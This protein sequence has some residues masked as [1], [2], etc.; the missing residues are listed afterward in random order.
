MEDSSRNNIAQ[1]SLAGLLL[2]TL[3]AAVV[4]LIREPRA[5]GLAITTLQ[6]AGGTVAIALPLGTLMAAIVTRTNLP[7]RRL[8][9]AAWC[10]LLFLPLYLQASAWDS[11]FGLQGWFTQWR[12]VPSARPEVWL[13]G[14]SAAIWLHALAAIPW[15]MLIVGQGL[16]QAEA[17]LEE[18]ALLDT[19]PAGVFWNVT[20][21]RALPNILAAGLL[22]GVVTAGE[23]TIT[24]IYRVRTY[25]EELY[26]NAALTADAVE[27]GLSI[28]PHIAIVAVLA[29]LAA[30]AALWL[31]PIGDRTAPRRL[32]V[33]ELGALRLPAFGLMLGLTILALGVPVGNLIYKAGLYID[34]SSGHA[35]QAWSA[36]RF[37]ASTFPDHMN[38]TRWEFAA[39]YYATLLIGISAATGAVVIGA[40]LA[41]A[42]R[43]GGWK[44]VPALLTTALGLA[45]PGPLVA[46]GVIWIL[47]RPSPTIFP[48]LYDKT[49]FAP[50]ITIV[51]RTLPLATMILWGAIR[52]IEQD[53]FDAAAADGASSWQQ[54]WRVVLPQRWPA[55]A[56]A[57]LMSF[58]L[59]AG[60]LAAS[61]LVI[62]PGRT[63]IA[64]QIFLLI[65]AG[66][67]NAEA[68][69][70]LGQLALFGTLAVIVL[71]LWKAD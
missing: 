12:A 10:V 43:S 27:L 53:Q 51:V 30:Q 22:V 40:A 14:M 18:Q 24:D 48:W 66:V 49:V 44:A 3:I 65:H 57:W 59:A 68:G 1:A 39:E 35:R 36:T 34:N 25:A 2:L 67:H 42:A 46:L 62:P 19:S 37:A 63:T 20:L 16:R 11:G 47:N 21:R 60:D 7:G 41:W 50:A 8:F 5:A 28:W 58:A 6:V 61:I 31:A 70:C 9:I 38:P 55:V 32:W 23:M 17:E 69:L 13:A 52:S 26:T 45:V 71:A 4:A 64:N 56:I 15:V 54:W 29:V 33:F